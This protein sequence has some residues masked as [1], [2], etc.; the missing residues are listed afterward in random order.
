MLVTAYR[1]V[2]LYGDSGAGKSSLVNAG[3]IPAAIEEGRA[4][5]RLRVQAR[6]NEELVLERMEAPEGDALVP[7]DE[8]SIRG[9][10][11]VE[12]LERRVRAACK[13]R[14]LLLVFD[15]FE[16]IVAL[17]ETADTQMSRQRIVKMIVRLHDD[18]LCRSSVCSCSE[19]TISVG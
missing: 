11:S 12:D 3:L 2:L 1:G 15:H 6:S 7:N 13:E 17:F 10:L 8:R 14:D 16:D 18:G 19:T 4:V 5:E 9:A